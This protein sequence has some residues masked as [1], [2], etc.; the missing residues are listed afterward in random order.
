MLE[1]LMEKSERDRRVWDA[2]A[3]SYENHIVGGHPEVA[4]YEA[5]EED[6]LDRILLYLIRDCGCRVHLFDVGCGSARLHCRYGMK[7]APDEDVAE[8]GEELPRVLRATNAHL[9]FDPRLAAGVHSVGGLD[10]SPEMIALAERKLNALGLGRRHHEKRFWLRHGSAFDLSP[11]KADPLP[12]AVTLCNSIGVMQ[13]PEGAE[14]LFRAL[15]RA[16]GRRGRPGVDQRVSA[17]GGGLACPGQLR[18][19]PER[20][21]PA[22]VASSR[23]LCLRGLCADSSRLQASS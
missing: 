8:S 12:V 1:L 20:F 22:P 13:G 18:I 23:D 9:R 2:C 21:G 4:A 11:K 19:D 5:F 17:R 3:Q 7:L 6:L 10:F 16:G 14:E 15:R